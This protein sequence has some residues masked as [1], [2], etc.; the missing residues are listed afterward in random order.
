MEG[1]E[2]S[3]RRLRTR[4]PS[5]EVIPSQHAPGGLRVGVRLYFRGRPPIVSGLGIPQ[6]WHPRP[7]A[8][9]PSILEAEWTL[10]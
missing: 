2:P 7:M 5:I 1:V 6:F 3:E 9:S 4:G 8:F 10:R